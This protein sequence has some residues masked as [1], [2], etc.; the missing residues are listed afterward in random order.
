MKIKWL[1]E[2]MKGIAYAIT[3]KIDEPED[4]FV[5]IIVTPDG[6]DRIERAVSYK[7]DSQ[8]TLTVE[9]IS[10]NG[11]NNIYTYPSTSWVKCHTED[12]S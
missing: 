12:M 10:E 1:E 6:H 11:S 8:Y 2:F 9:A 5:M 7:M 3:P 4:P